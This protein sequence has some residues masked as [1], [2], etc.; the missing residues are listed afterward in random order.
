MGEKVNEEQVANLLAILRTDTSVDVKVRQINN[1]KSSIKTNA[2]P[3]SCVAPL[4][5]ATRTT[6]NSSHTAL[7][8]TGF[9][10]L[11]HLLTRM[12]GQE[13][14]HIVK[15]AARTLP[16]VMEKMGDLKEKYR[17][18]AAQCLTTFWK[19]APMDVERIVKNVGLVGKNS[20]MKEASMHWIVLVRNS[21]LAESRFCFTNGWL[22]DAPR[23]WYAVQE[24]RNNFDG[25]TR[26]RGRHGSRYCAKLSHRTVPVR[27]C[28][29]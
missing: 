5:E 11:N 17:Q 10:T 25:T 7:V 3:D 14:K 18:L 15:E 6:M 20:R 8:N 24:L 1:A 19:Y 13:P 12:S 22:A 9:S 29:Q 28:Q 27:I 21:A 4:F 16:V 2:V 23:K 26:R